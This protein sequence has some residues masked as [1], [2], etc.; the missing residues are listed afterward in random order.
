MQAIILTLCTEDYL[1]LQQLAALLNRR[2]KGLQEDHL[3]PM[4]RAGRLQMRFP[5]NP[6][7]PQQAYRAAKY[8]WNW[9]TNSRG[10]RIGTYDRLWRARSD[11][12]K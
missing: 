6:N 1:T 11:E 4:T 10:A 12:W 3:T 5:D 8:G 7:H 9:M 2:S